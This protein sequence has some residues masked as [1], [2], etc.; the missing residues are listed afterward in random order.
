MHTEKAEDVDFAFCSEY[1]FQLPRFSLKN[2]LVPC[3]LGYAGHH[4]PDHHCHCPH[5]R[6][7]HDGDDNSEDQVARPVRERQGEG[8]KISAFRRNVYKV[9]LILIMI[10]L[11]KK[12]AT[13]TTKQY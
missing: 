9:M 4:P 11:M 10:M 7:Q 1:T 3:P 13:M 12:K 6:H 2:C 5:P 8:G